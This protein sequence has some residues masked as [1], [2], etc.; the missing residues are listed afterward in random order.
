MGRVELVQARLIQRIGRFMGCTGQV[1]MDFFLEGRLQSVI[2][3]RVGRYNRLDYIG[4]K[5]PVRLGP[6]GIRFHSSS[7]FF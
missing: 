5:G 7:F 2:G 1:W 3:S 6:R 4:F